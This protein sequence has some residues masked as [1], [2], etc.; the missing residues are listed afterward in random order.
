MDLHRLR[1]FKVLVLCVHSLILP[2]T[3]RIYLEQLMIVDLEGLVD[4]A[5]CY[6]IVHHQ[7]RSRPMHSAVHCSNTWCI[8]EV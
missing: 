5:H 4:F 3:R 8:R 2:Y 7:S 6:V 1:C